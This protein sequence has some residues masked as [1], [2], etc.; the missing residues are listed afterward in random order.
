MLLF[1][2]CFCF[3]FYFLSPLSSSLIFSSLFVCW[4]LTHWPHKV[5]TQRTERRLTKKCSHKLMPTYLMHPSVF[6]ST[7][8]SLKTSE[9]ERSRCILIHFLLTLFCKKKKQKNL[10]Q[11]NCLIF[12][13]PKQSF[14]R[15]T[16]LTLPAAAVPLAT[17]I[18]VTLIIHTKHKPH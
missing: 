8:T 10:I 14:E 12:S 13:S 18:T 16:A 1:L 3:Y 15:I 7:T 11:V 9:L 6:N 4:C 17:A 2:L 5:G